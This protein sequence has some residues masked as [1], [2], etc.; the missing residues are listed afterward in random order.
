[1]KISKVNASLT[2]KSFLILIFT[3]VEVTFET[4]GKHSV[5]FF[6]KLPQLPKNGGR[7]KS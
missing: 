3:F 4:W 5:A 6:S 7:I 1:M 2:T